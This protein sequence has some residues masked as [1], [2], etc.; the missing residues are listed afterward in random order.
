MVGTAVRARDHSFY[1]YR[2]ETIYLVVYYLAWPAAST[3][4]LVVVRTNLPY[5]VIPRLFLGEFREISWAVGV[6]VFKV[7]AC[8]QAPFNHFCRK[9]NPR[10]DSLLMESQVEWGGILIGTAREVKWILIGLRTR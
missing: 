10:F 1:V 4:W 3:R 9:L 8:R 7:L 5:I 6:R 2:R